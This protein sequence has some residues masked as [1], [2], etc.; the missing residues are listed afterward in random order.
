MFIVLFLNF[1]TQTAF[2]FPGM[3][4]HGYINCQACHVSPTGGGLLTQYGRA[5]SNEVLSSTGSEEE[6][7]FLYDLIKQPEWL[8]LGGDAR[9]LVLYRDTPTIREGRVI[10]MQLD[11]EAGL[12]FDPF[13]A[14]GTFGYK[15]TPQPE[16]LREH[17]ISRRHYL[18]YR[19]TEEIGFRLGRFN[20]GYGINTD[21][22][23]ITIKRGLG[24]DQ[25]TESYNIESSYINESINFYLTGIFGRID[26]PKL[27]R[28]KGFA[29][30]ASSGFA[31]T[32]KL[33]ASYFNGK[34]DLTHRHVFGP[35]GVLG[36]TPELVLMSEIDFQ[37]VKDNLPST[38]RVWGY[39]NYQKLDYEFLKGVHGFLTQEYSQLD[40]STDRTKVQTYGVGGRYFPRPHIELSAA[41]NV[42]TR[43]TLNANTYL[44]YLNLHYYF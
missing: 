19:A 22:H 7:V 3:V 42:S 38:D 12:S 30:S 9:T 41:F 13:Y 31:D 23:A 2:A 36:F 29:V 33:G 37:A 21:D 44:S 14:V 25:E 5:L 27:D 4:S 40:W 34:N 18:G 32:F 15:D 10:I 20:P 1:L 6:S 8:N 24:W 39:V 11:L 17:L 35:F 28:E 43:P 16:P 26:E